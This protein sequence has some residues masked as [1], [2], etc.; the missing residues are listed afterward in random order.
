MSLRRLM[1]MPVVT[2]GKLTG[3]VER[4]T[5]T[6]DGRRLHGLVLRHGLGGAKWLPA[7]QLL[8]LGETSVLAQGAPQKLPREAQQRLGTVYHAQG[9]CLGLVS[10]ALLHPERMTVLALEI[11]YGPLYQLA[12]RS[13]YATEYSV[14]PAPPRA[15]ADV[16][17]EVV[18]S[19]L[20][21]WQAVGALAGKEVE[22][23]C[24]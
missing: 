24:Q 2:R 12:G 15:A 5:L 23:K 7:A 21:P 4:A 10:D 9:L 22:P 6:A 1:G 16:A 18:I 20:K 14:R 3:W 19:E 8:Q 11:S 13:A 17:R